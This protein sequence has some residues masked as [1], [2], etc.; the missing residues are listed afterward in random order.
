MR[1][2]SDCFGCCARPGD[3]AKPVLK[4]PAQD[5]VQPACLNFAAFAASAPK[6][7]HLPIEFSRNV[8]PYEF[9]ISVI[10]FMVFL[11]NLPN[12]S[13]NGQ[14]P[15]DHRRHVWLRRCVHLGR[16]VV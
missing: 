6:Y 14:P 16:A 10:T 15:L 9:T 3:T 11:L 5:A 8:L 13:G 7:G 12:G 2:V 1:S 4:H